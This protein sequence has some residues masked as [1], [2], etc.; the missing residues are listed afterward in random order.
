MQ[1]AGAPAGSESGVSE[2][3]LDLKG[4]GELAQGGED[5]PVLGAV[6]TR[7]PF[8]TLLWGSGTDFEDGS[9]PWDPYPEPHLWL[10]TLVARTPLGGKIRA[11]PSLGQCLLEELGVLG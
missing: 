1:K 9:N 2:S 10:G 4:V 7:V 3:E 5:Q 8:L 6:G 11:T